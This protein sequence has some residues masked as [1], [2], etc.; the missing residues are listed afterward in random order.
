MVL[1]WWH[2]KDEN[3]WKD[4][5]SCWEMTLDWHAHCTALWAHVLAGT[6]RRAFILVNQLFN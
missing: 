3:N 6:V 5:E 4:E 1:H 2:L